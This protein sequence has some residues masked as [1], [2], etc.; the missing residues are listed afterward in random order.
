MNIDFGQLSGYIVYNSQTRAIELGS[1]PAEQ[2][3]L[4]LYLVFIELKDNNP[5]GSLSSN[6][7]LGINILPPTTDT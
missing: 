4:G 5:L 1:F 3:P 2:V 7:Q 6:Y